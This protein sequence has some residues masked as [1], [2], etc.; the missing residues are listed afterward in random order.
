VDRD[1]SI[2]VFDGAD[3]VRVI[4]TANPVGQGGNT[5]LSVAGNFRSYRWY[6][7]LEQT[8]TITVSPANPA[9]FGVSVTGPDGCPRRGAITIGVMPSHA[10]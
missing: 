2:D 7:G 4:A 6:P 1:F 5:T 8:P 9:T 3:F 10:P